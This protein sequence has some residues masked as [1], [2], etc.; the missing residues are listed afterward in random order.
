MAITQ[1][2]YTADDKVIGDVFSSDEHNELKDVVNQKTDAA[3]AI[4]IEGDQAI[5]GNLSVEQI[6]ATSGD[7]SGRITITDADDQ[8]RFISNDPG[9]N[10]S[11]DRDTFIMTKAESNLDFY[12]Y[13]VTDS[14]GKFY[15]TTEGNGWFANKLYADGRVTISH[16]E[17]GSD[18]KALVLSSGVTATTTSTDIVFSRENADTARIRHSNTYDTTF[19]IRGND[20]NLKKKIVLGSQTG[21][22]SSYG[23]ALFHGDAEVTSLNTITSGISIPARISGSTYD[24]SGVFISS[25]TSTGFAGNV[26]NTCGS[27]FF[28]ESSDRKFGFALDYFGDTEGIFDANKLYINRFQ[29]SLTPTPVM[30]FPRTSST[31]EF[32][33]DIASKFYNATKDAYQTKPWFL[34]YGNG[35][36]DQVEAVIQIDGTLVIGAGEAGT[37]VMSNIGRAASNSA[38]YE[39][40]YLASDYDMKFITNLQNGYASKKE[41]TLAANGDLTIEGVAHA[42]NFQFTSDISLKENIKPLETSL[43]IEFIEFNFKNDDTTRY[44]V[45]AQAVQEALPELVSEDHNGDLTVSMVDLL[46]LKVAELENKI[47]DLTK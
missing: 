47:K 28:R 46:I 10:T 29:N 5:V 16:N 38:V 1:S 9:G 35:S 34:N 33:G 42:T 12:V 2:Q 22:G 32:W 40:L 19:S 39:K 37:A 8:I 43:D 25:L 6:G 13:S 14:A 4:L 20:N 27:V 3:N 45:S 41:M 23:V 17:N 24:T 15:V 26:N 7:F 18:S 21:T 30:S 44:G 36:G 31:V 11:L